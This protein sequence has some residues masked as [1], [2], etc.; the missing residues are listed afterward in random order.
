[1]THPRIWALMGFK[2]VGKTTVG[3]TLAQ[4]L[5]CRFFDLD[6][7]I[8]KKYDAQQQSSLTCRQIM[9]K[10]SEEFFSELEHLA[11]TQFIDDQT[12]DCVLALGGRTPLNK[13]NQQILKNPQSNCVL[14]YLEARRDQVFIRMMENGRPAFIPPE[15]DAKKIFDDLWDMRS[16]VYE[17]LADITIVNTEIIKKA[18]NEILKNLQKRGD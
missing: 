7:L 13:K 15:A 3:Q 16:P 17:R 6:R 5:Q 18:V 12:E 14:I 4:E 10:Q 9:R 2:A 1:M 11:L 8:E